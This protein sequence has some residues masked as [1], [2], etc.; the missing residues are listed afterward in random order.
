MLWLTAYVLATHADFARPTTISNEASQELVA[1]FFEANMRR[2]LVVARI[3]F[4]CEN[5]SI[6]EI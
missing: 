5:A 6:R 2:L 1:T 3:I 4:K